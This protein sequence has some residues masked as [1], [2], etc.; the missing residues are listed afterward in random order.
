MDPISISIAPFAV[1]LYT[2]GLSLAIFLA[3]FAVIFGLSRFVGGEKKQG[4]LIGG[5]TLIVAVALGLTTTVSL[6][7]A[8]VEHRE[9]QINRIENSLSKDLGIPVSIAGEDIW[10]IVDSP[11]SLGF[12][13]ALKLS[14]EL[15]G[16]TYWLALEAR[17]RE[18]KGGDYVFELYRA[19][20]PLPI[21]E[22]VESINYPALT[23]EGLSPETS[24]DR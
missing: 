12:S 2:A 21:L 19:G 5:V 16:E 17:Q 9:A 8:R 20:E 6:N 22:Y 11:Q 18:P 14:Y 24:E 4:S 7:T 3:I 13:R 1:A 15:D 10:K 23:P